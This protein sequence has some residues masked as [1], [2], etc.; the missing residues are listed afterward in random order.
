MRY[1]TI[2]LSLACSEIRCDNSVPGRAVSPHQRAAVEH[3][4]ARSA[5][6]DLPATPLGSQRLPAPAGAFGR[7]E[8]LHHT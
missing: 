5:G 2:T 3:A 4:S 1:V 7:H 6:G 8:E